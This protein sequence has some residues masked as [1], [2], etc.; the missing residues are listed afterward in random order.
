MP[1]SPP[2]SRA[3]TARSLLGGLARCVLVALLFAIATAGPAVASPAIA[4]SSSHDGG[5][6]GLR[7]VEAP[8]ATADD[9][10]AQQYIVDHLAPGAVI[11]RK[12]EVSNNTAA[13]LDVALYPA[14]A[15]IAN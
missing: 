6:I 5:S 7:L 14:A 4:R 11:H 13:P 3:A 15:S 8:A 10:R 12:I 2:V 9:P 1:Q